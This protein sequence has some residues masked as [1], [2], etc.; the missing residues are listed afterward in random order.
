METLP[1]DPVHPLFLWYMP[2]VGALVILIGAYITILAIR[3]SALK[4]QKEESIEIMG[5][6]FN[7]STLMAIFL[8]GLAFYGPVCFIYYNKFDTIEARM[9]EVEISQKL[10][11]AR[12]KDMVSAMTEMG[13]CPLFVNIELEGEPESEFP[14]INKLQCTGTM[15]RGKLKVGFAISLGPGDYLQLTSVDARQDPEFREIRLMEL[16]DDGRV[17]RTWIAKETDN[18]AINLFN[19]VTNPLK[20]K[21]ANS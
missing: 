8:V 18:S 3:R 21:K 9:R 15:E 12:Y 19:Y 14:I 11:E 16:A 17:L 4:D 5:A 1:A 20:F 2:V 10:Y 7:I 6:K 13:K